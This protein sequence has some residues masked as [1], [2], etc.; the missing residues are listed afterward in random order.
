MKKLIFTGLLLTCLATVSAQIVVNPDGTH[1]VVSGSHIIN[2]NGTVSAIHGD[3][4]I[5]SD[6]SISAIHGN[7]IVNSNGTISAIHG[8]HIINMNSGTISVVQGVYPLHENGSLN[9][10]QSNL[11]LPEISP[12]NQK[13][14][15]FNPFKM[16]NYSDSLRT[17]DPTSKETRSKK[18]IKLSKKDKK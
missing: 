12:S 4:I 11:L 1:S 6:G 16:V 15:S 10:L 5:S 13:K 8:S 9:L 7:H 3:H 14:Y 2:S 18:R 17:Y